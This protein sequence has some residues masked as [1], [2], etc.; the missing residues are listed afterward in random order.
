MDAD[1]SENYSRCAKSIV[2]VGPPDAWSQ[3]Q[4]TQ[5]L[6]LPLEIVPEVSPYAEPGSATLPVRVLYAGQ[7]LKGALVKLTNLERD[8]APFEMQLTDTAGRASF[9]MPAAGSW[10]LNVTWTKTQPVS[11]E[12]DFETT[13]SSLSFGFH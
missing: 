7:P 3:A 4:V 8:A 13:F 1:G 11:S 2:Q 6:G 12:T 5:P 9:A 10:L